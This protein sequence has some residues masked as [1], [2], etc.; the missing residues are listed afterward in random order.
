MSKKRPNPYTGEYEDR[1]V[2]L[3]QLITLEND[4]CN[5]SMI[6]HSNPI[7]NQFV[8]SD[9]I[10]EF[11]NNDYVDLTGDRYLYMNHYW[12]IDVNFTIEITGYNLQDKVVHTFLKRQDSDNDYIKVWYDR[13]EK[14]IRADKKVG[15]YLLPFRSVNKIDIPYDAN[16]SILITNIN[17]RLG[18]EAI[19]N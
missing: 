6:V 15:K 11:V 5:A 1:E 14:L 2:R 17:G 7:C 8:P 13:E 9:G 18:L 10:Y 3:Q 19:L 16:F 12:T 4:A